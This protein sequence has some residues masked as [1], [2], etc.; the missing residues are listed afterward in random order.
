M[1]DPLEQLDSDALARDLARATAGPVEVPQ[2]IDSA[3]LARASD[4]LSDRAAPLVAG[5]IGRIRRRFSVAAAASIVIAGGWLAFVFL[6]GGPKTP[7][8][9]PSSPA[10]ARAEDV[11]GNGR[12]D[13][14]DAFALARRID[15][16]DG[17][18]EGRPS[19]DRPDRVD[20][21]FDVNGDAVVDDRDVDLIAAR[22]VLLEK[23]A[24]G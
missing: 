13:M 8:S 24:S 20:L 22:A 15:R 4:Q 5:R 17:I 23:E 1:N 11:D 6:N 2:A 14:L 9:P 21:S 10:I 3:I 18:S 7:E 12:V 19:R 16:R